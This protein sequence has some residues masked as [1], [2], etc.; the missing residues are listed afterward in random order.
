[1]Y[2]RKFI[3]LR[4]DLG[5]ITGRNPKGHGKLEMKGPRGFVSV[6]IENA[7]EQDVYNVAFIAKDKSSPILNLGKIFTDDLGRGKGDYSFMQKEVLLES[8]KGILVMK[9]TE[10][11]LGGYID[12]EDG[13]I[14][15]YIETIFEI[16]NMEE[17]ELV[18]EIEPDKKPLEEFLMEPEDEIESELED[19]P[20]ETIIEDIIIEEDLSEEINFVEDSFEES[21]IRID[22]VEDMVEEDIILEPGVDLDE[23]HMEP[24][25]QTIEHIKKLNQKNQTTN[26]VLSILRFFPYIDP[27]KYN[28][29]GYNWW[30]VELDKENEYS[31]FLPYFSHL[32]G[33]SNKEPYQ[34]DMVTCTQLMNKYQH[35]LFGLYNENEEVKY[36]VYGVPGSFSKSEHPNKGLSGFNTWYQGINVEGYWIVYIDP[37]TGKSVNPF[38]IMDPI[39]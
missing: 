6:T 13:T 5:T 36:F 25:Y 28:L 29:K 23:D 10:I 17:D 2:T 4:K 26:Y 19:R 16:P 1:M 24:D 9:D 18:L 12:K 3:I 35:Y 39:N 31:S 30:M 11:L 37:M 38:N 14:E 21:N 15:R 7:N 20:E 22:N 32:A 34:S 27:F 33:G 8:I